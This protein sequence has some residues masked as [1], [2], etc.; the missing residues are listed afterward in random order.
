M[1]IN[2][3][4]NEESTG[5][6]GALL[7]LCIYLGFQNHHLNQMIQEYQSSL[8]EANDNIESANGTINTLNSQIEDAQSEAWS[9]YETMGQT[10]EDLETTDDTEDIVLD[11]HP[12]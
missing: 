4:M 9:D 8:S 10:L 1:A 12:N 2:S 7:V 5:F 11:P 6:T 3:S